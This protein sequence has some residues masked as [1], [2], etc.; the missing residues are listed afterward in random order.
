MGVEF[1]YTSGV[2]FQMQAGYGEEF[3]TGTTS[4]FT[5]ETSWTNE[6][7]FGGKVENFPN[8]YG[9]QV[10]DWAQHCQYEMR[11]YQYELIETSSFGQETRYTVLDY[12]V[13][14][15]SPF[16][17]QYGGES[18]GLD[19]SDSEAMANCH[20]GNVTG[21]TPQ[22][23]ND[24]F[25]AYPDGSA[26]F[27]VVANDT[28]N[29]LR[30]TGTTQPQN[31]NVSFTEHSITYTPDEGFTGTDSFTYTISDGTTTSEGTVT[32]EVAP[33]ELFL[34]MINRLGG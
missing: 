32:V 4:E 1:D 28:G 6:V 16:M 14:E 25:S 3:T 29:N 9:Q 15:G 10:W 13:P 22:T 5:T 20:N 19:R 33:A 27:N 8:E 24:Q 18:F 7:D 26:T 30:I 31:G 23:S 2:I 17:D 11:P 34:P 12:I 21:N